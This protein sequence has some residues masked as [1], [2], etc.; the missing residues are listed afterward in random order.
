MSETSLS[1]D[2]FMKRLNADSMLVPGATEPER[3][4]WFEIRATETRI[5]ELRTYIRNHGF[6]GR[7]D[8]KGREIDG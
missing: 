6:H 3:I 4:Y 5:K 8:V 1:Y 2:E 7:F